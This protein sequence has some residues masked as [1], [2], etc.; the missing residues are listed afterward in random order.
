MQFSDF[1][2]K[3]TAHS[4]ILEL[5]DDLGQALATGDH[6]A[7]FGG[8]NPAAIPGVQRVIEDHL[9]S[10]MKRPEVLHSYLGNYDTPQGNQLFIQT[11]V[12]Y[13]NNEMGWQITPDHI[14][15]TPGSQTGFFMLFNLLAGDS[16]G[17][18]RTILFPL[19]PEYIGY[20]DQGIQ[21][22]MFEA[23][24][25]NIEIH[26]DHTF[27]YGI[28]FDSLKIES[29]HAAICISRPT[30]P[31]GNVVTDEELARL[32]DLAKKHGIPL[33][34][35]NAYGL[36]FPG[37]I[38]QNAHLPK[39]DEQV[40]YS[41]SLSKVGLPSSRVGIFVAR[42]EIAA[43]ISKANA[44]LSLA[45][46][47]L[48]Q[49]LGTS[50]IRDGS[51]G[52]ICRDHIQP[53]YRGAEKYAQA[54]LADKLDGLPY[55]LHEYEGAYFLWLWLPDLPITSK[56]LY[57]RLKSR[58]VI[59]VPGEYFFPGLSDPKWPHQRECLRLNFAR[60][61]HEIDAGITILAEEVSRAY[62]EALVA[63]KV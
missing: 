23:N 37:V 61:K 50:L 34:I 8:G 6:V 19:V 38:T 63:V 49:A 31:S 57:S 10:L 52:R 46:P 12:D 20:A 42:P 62:A 13:L 29:H 48:G 60:P 26:G 30:N 35:D 9:A 14:A 58:G 16:R 47:T 22:G 51:L 25:P 33:I 44:I 32:S 3:F 4:G 59:V 55:R 17:T 41:F 36:P 15:I 11:I 43:A 2:Q 1:G 24:R 53:Y 45:S 40:V 7:M 5:M 56:E 39:W 18:K 27:K 28:D 21:E 54:V